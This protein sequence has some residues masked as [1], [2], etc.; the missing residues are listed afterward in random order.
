ME[1]PQQEPLRGNSSLGSIFSQITNSIL[2]K[3]MVIFILVLILLIPLNMIN[4]LIQERKFREERVSQEI[5]SKWGR[6]QIIASP[7]VAV[8]YDVVKERIERVSNTENRIY[9]EVKTEW[10]YLLPNTSN[11][12]TSV[13]PESRDR[14]IYKAVVYHSKIN[15]K[16]DFIGFDLEKLK[17]DSS[18]LKW[19]EAKLIFGVEDF[20]G[21]SKNPVIIWKG[22]EVEFVKDIQEPKL[23]TGN[24]SMD[25]PLENNE[26][27][28]SG[29]EIKMELKGSKSLNFLPISKQTKI[30]ASGEWE[31]PSFNGQ[32]LPDH[33]EVNKSFKADWS[34][35]SFNR[36][37]PTQW[38]G[39][40]EYIY[41]FIGLD[42]NSEDVAADAANYAATT[43]EFP[44]P[45][46]GTSEL[47]SSDNDMVQIKFLPSINSYQKTS[48]VAKYGIL[49]IAL[50]F[51][52]LIFM[53]VIK[54]QRV[55]LIQYI[56][57]G[58]AMVLFYALLLA[59]SE[60]FGFNKAYILSGLMTI[61]LIS[62]FVAGITKNRNSAILFGII[63][64][65]FYSFIFIL[66]QLRDYSLIVGT[67]G[68]FIILAVLMRLS[69]KIKWDQIEQK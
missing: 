21:L 32:Y 66:M 11:I 40:A 67:L 28:K 7:I 2:L 34:I 12:E 41:Q 24:L 52:S 57:I 60:H 62:S 53:E 20:K 18:K 19:K 64:T 50:S 68:I 4:D 44:E 47:I 3:V 6:D 16:G 5:A 36:K 33:R 61:L 58:F 15:I 51:V 30:H 65:V 29:F 9:E 59:I 23:F 54:R 25:L 69:S 42:L 55:H 31:N 22:K 26:S 14:G 39:T 10:A 49:I 37:L 43:A 27:L 8:P 13:K 1:N 63:L 45:K 38:N 48:R 56:L 35:P 46:S 17:V